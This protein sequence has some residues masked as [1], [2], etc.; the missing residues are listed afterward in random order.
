[1]HKIQPS[2]Y[3]A[4]QVTTLILIIVS[5]KTFSTNSRTATDMNCLENPSNERLHTTKK[6]P[7]FQVKCPALLIDRNQ[8]YFGC[9]K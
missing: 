9:T 5:H 3:T 7:V 6:V 1:M 4:V 8:T 2:S